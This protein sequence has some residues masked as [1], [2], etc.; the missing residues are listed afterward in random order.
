[1]PTPLNQTPSTHRNNR[2]APAAFG[3]IRRT[4]DIGL[5]I[6]RRTESHHGRS[7]QLL[8]HAAEYL[9]DSRLFLIST[10]ASSDEEAIRVLMRLSREVFD[11]YAALTQQS[12]PVTDWIMNQAIRI[13]GAA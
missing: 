8:G 4:A 1:M 13:Y 7:L 9:A 10:S 11:D 2:P 12:H 3:D 5:T 6:H